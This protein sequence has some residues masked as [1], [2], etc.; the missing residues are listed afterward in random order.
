MRSKLILTL[1][2]LAIL[3]SMGGASAN[4]LS[5]WAYGEDE[6]GW[7]NSTYLKADVY[8]DSGLVYEASITSY[9]T[10]V[11]I[12][13]ETNVYVNMWHINSTYYPRTYWV[14]TQ[15]SDYPLLVFLPN[16]S[17]TVVSTIFHFYLPTG[18][19]SDDVIVRIN[20]VS[21]G[22]ERELAS[23]KLNVN[24]EFQCYLKAGKSI[25]VVVEHGS[26]SHSYSYTPTISETVPITISSGITPTTYFTSHN[27]RYWYTQ[28]IATNRTMTF[29]YK[30][31]SG[32][33]VNI[34]ATW[35]LNGTTDVY[36]TTVNG[37]SD[38]S[39]TYSVAG[40]NTSSFL[41]RWSATNGMEG[42]Y[43]FTHEQSDIMTVFDS[44][45]RMGIALGLILLVL[46]ISTATVGGVGILVAFSLV[47]LFS[48]IGWLPIPSL[49]LWLM[50]L[51]AFFAAIGAGIRRVGG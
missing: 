7:I 47:V 21:S 18:W 40:N 28:D 14:G 16:N 49:L 5:I 46:L 13:G 50:G 11:D 30:D 41:L 4:V 33:T 32:D 31:F 15:T 3:L 48:S 8:A 9:P 45:M 44:D 23:G 39:I 38:A 17:T 27:V 25:T 26:E 51:V 34:T 36:N 37:T 6:G 10:N 20:G 2:L 22:Y 1:V 12:T 43:W 42:S 35:Y 24:N 19:S 29:H